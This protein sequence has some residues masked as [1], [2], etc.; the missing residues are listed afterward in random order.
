MTTASNAPGHHN[1]C[2]KPRLRASTVFLFPSQPR[3]RPRHDAPRP[4]ESPRPDEEAARLPPRP[5]AAFASAPFFACLSFLPEPGGFCASGN[6]EGGASVLSAAAVP[7]AASPG[8]VD[9]PAGLGGAGAGRA[10]AAAALRDACCWGA[11]SWGPVP[12]NCVSAWARLGETGGLARS[13]AARGGVAKTSRSW[14]PFPAFGGLSAA[15]LGLAAVRFGLPGLA[16]FALA[17]AARAGAPVTMLPPC[18]FLTS[19][20]DGRGRNAKACV[21]EGGSEPGDRQRPRG[22]RATRGVEAKR[23]KAAGMHVVGPS[24]HAGAFVR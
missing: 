22:L 7:P 14:P 17:L 8:V 16:S 13:L 23:P 20:Q 18:L 2:Q 12:S 15:A 6:G 11:S 4:L 19:W 9:G 5:V 1:T 24:A 21:P 10:R 3:P